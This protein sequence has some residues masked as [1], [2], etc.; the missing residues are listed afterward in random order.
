MMG[1]GLSPGATSGLQSLLPRSRL[2]LGIAAILL[3]ALLAILAIHQLRPTSAVPPGAPALEFSSGRALTHIKAITHKPR[4]LGTA[5]HSAVRDYILNELTTAGLIPEVQ[6]TTATNS[7]GNA[8]LRAAT[9]ENITARLKGTSNTRAILLVSHYDSVPASFGASDD[10]S[11][12]GVLLET[13]RALKSGPALNNDVIFLFT[14]AEEIG[15]LG[16]HAFVNEHPWARE[17]GLVVNFEARGTGGPSILF[18][19]SDQN[20]GLIKEFSKA[21]PHPVANSFAYEIYRLLPNDTDLTV[22]K[23]AGLPGLNF[24]YIDRS[25]HYHTQLDSIE[26]IDERSVQHH[27]AYALA[28]TKHF[29]N[30]DLLNV[31]ERNAVYFDVLGL[32]LVRYPGAVV[33]LIT[34]L[35]TVLFSG[36]VVLGWRKGRFTLRGLAL[37]LVVQ[38]VTLI[39]VPAGFALGWMLLQRLLNVFGRSSQAIAYQSKL[40]FIG[41]ALLAI[42][43]SYIATAAVLPKIRIENFMASSLVWWILLLILTSALL[44]GVTYLLSWPMLFCLPGFGYLLLTEGQKPRPV[45]LIFFFLLAVMPALLSLA[46]A[47]YLIFTGLNLNSIGIIIAM[48]IAVCVLLIPHFLS[49]RLGNDRVFAIVIALVG[50]VFIGVAAFKST[51]D[52]QHPRLNSLFYGL[53]A[54]TGKA[55]W[56][57]FDG[58]PDEWTSRVLS[59]NA[60]RRAA[61]EFFATGR[62]GLLLQADAAPVTLPA[63]NA[64]V[65]SDSTQN[66]VRTMR[67]RLTSPRGAPVL[68]V[69]LDSVKNLQGVWVNGKRFEVEGTTGLSQRMRSWSLH[70]YNVLPEG[71]ELTLQLSSEESLKMRVVDQSYGLPDLPEGTLVSRP[72]G[73]IPAPVVYNDATVVSKSFS[74]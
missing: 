12:V 17:V 24:A 46:P 59:A 73:I 70:Y 29:G 13:L 72:A 52:A 50:V 28:L 48:L 41:F 43:I 68:S 5:E 45:L 31:K 44:P 30:L 18:E 69:Y 11:G 15:L 25:T 61:P 74:Y 40:Y 65:L 2:G 34:V 42:A 27:G 49:L 6:R 60:Q 14:D 62:A 8:G 57:S 54:D 67:L 33:P 32:F 10:G 20:G 55:I 39:V 22:F 56:A 4:P 47:I 38:L 58:K 37:G 9:V 3:M 53:N 66:T 51:H 23:N 36:L 26:E 64:S 16:A 21:A 19:T 7:L 1:D 71:I 63:P 35:L